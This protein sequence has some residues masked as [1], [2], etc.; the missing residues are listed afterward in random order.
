[1]TSKTTNIYEIKL[2]GYTIRPYHDGPVSIGWQWCHDEYDG[3]E[4]R[5]IGLERRLQD[6]IYSVQ[7]QFLERIDQGIDDHLTAIQNIENG[8][9]DAEGLDDA[10]DREDKGIGLR[11]IMNDI[12]DIIGAP[13]NG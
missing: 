7:Q 6:C 2:L 3:P 11:T 9:P 4:D 8:N 12:D 5:R 13:S 1:M 10:I